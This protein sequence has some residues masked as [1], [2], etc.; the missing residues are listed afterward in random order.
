MSNM[1][2]VVILYGAISSGK[3]ATCLE[4]VE[5]ARKDVPLAGI[6]TK[7]V[8]DEGEVV[9]YDCIDMSTDEE[10]PL[11]RLAR[12]LDDPDWLPLYLE[13]FVFSTSGFRR[14][15]EVLEISVASLGPP[16]LVF[17]DEFGRLEARGGGLLR[18][19]EAVLSGLREF[20]VAVATCRTNLLSHVEGMVRGAGHQ[21]YVRQPGD[22][23]ELW[24]WMKA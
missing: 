23:A 24:A 5:L 1:S 6:I 4:L 7:R 22:A 11:V 3:T 9:G 13:K 20:D 12:D 8:L 17:V 10:F 19:V 18:G 14:A 16:R 2:R 15:N 21:A